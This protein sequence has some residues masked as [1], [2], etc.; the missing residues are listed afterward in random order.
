MDLSTVFYR[1]LYICETCIKNTP[2]VCAR[3]T[4]WE[5]ADYLDSVAVSSNKVLEQESMERR[6]II[7]FLFGT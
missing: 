3:C 2:C 4:N 6:V 7:S 1:F 5:Y